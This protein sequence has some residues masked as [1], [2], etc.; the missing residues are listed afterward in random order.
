MIEKLKSIELFLKKKGITLLKQLEWL[1]K[2]N[3]PEDIAMETIVEVY[4]GLKK[5]S[6]E[7]LNKESYPKSMRHLMEK[8]LP[9][10]FWIDRYTLQLCKEKMRN[11]LAERLAGNASATTHL[12]AN[13][14]GYY[15]KMLTIYIV[16]SSSIT[17]SFAIVCVS[18]YMGWW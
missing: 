13:D 7:H 8:D 18:I 12:I 4:S 16:L 17:I 5:G 9:E 2:A 14:M 3:I 10:H 15:M 11:V 6:K 1:K